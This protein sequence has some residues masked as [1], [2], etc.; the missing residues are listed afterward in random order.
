[1]NYTVTPS[2]A[3]APVSYASSLSTRFPTAVSAFPTCIVYHVH[4]LPH[5]ERLLTQDKTLLGNVRRRG[6]MYLMR[7]WRSLWRGE[8]LGEECFV[9]YVC[10]LSSF[11]SS[12]FPFANILS[13]FLKIPFINLF[14]EKHAYPPFLVVFL[15][16]HHIPQNSYIS[17]FVLV[18]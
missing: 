11:I 14:S 17:C 15:S 9:F 10:V 4:S 3:Y 12:F 7:G 1:M 16:P 8:S 2:N 13:T 6:C 5:I 18:D